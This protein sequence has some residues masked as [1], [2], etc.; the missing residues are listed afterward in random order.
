MLPLKKWSSA[1]VVAWAEENCPDVVPTLKKEECGG[2]TLAGLRK[3]EFKEFF[4]AMKGA[5]FY[6]HL[7]GAPSALPF[8]RA[9]TPQQMR[10]SWDPMLVLH[11]ITELLL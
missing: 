9:L 3:E 8:P 5:A 4:G 10:D 11:N 6:G 1:Q 2:A 7:L